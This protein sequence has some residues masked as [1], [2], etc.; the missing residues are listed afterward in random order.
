MRLD[1]SAA[2]TNALTRLR[3]AVET[4]RV[5]APINSLTVQAVGLGALSDVADQLSTLDRAGL[6]AL[7]DAV[8]A[9]RDRANSHKPQL[10]WTGPD[11]R[12]SLSRDTAVVVQSLFTEARE[13]IL[14]AGFR[15]DHGESLLSALHS[16]MKD[17]GI[18]CRLYGD[19][20]EA[21]EFIHRNWPFGLPHPDVYAFVAEAGIY[22]SLHAKC[23]V[24]DHSRVLITSANFT[25]RGQTRNIEVGVLHEDRALAEALEQQFFSAEQA[26][27]FVPVR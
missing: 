8:L 1:L 10:V 24:A 23:V 15:F 27:A 3:N 26:G 7:M 17:R 16:A 6:L 22:A 20:R 13:S 12:G 9:E 5:T 21:D 18:S 2:S 11:G 4:G 19:A 14:I 25:D